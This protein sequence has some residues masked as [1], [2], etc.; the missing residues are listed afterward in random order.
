M[1]NT[2]TVSN[3][4][5][6]PLNIRIRQEQRNMIEKAARILDKTVS[7]FV[8]DAALKDAENTLLDRTSFH[9]E[10]EAWELF[11]KA[12]NTP[13]AENAGLRNL[14]LRKPVWEK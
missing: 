9:L 1:P 6:T 7:D 12:L 5:P 8:R 10:P 14:M 13:P 3:L 4:K 2:S 11:N